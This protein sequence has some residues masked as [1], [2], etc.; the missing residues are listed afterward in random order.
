MF[1]LKPL[2]R[3]NSMFFFF[4]SLFIWGKF[5]GSN[6]L[7]CGNALITFA[8]GG[9]P[10]QLC[11]PPRLIL[12]VRECNQQPSGHKLA[13][14]IFRPPLSKSLLGLYKCLEVYYQSLNSGANSSF[15]KRFTILKLFRTV[16]LFV[17]FKAD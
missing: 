16:Y 13:S 15:C 7:L 11:P 2:E 1:S 10:V 8:P 6:A 3:K 9:C 4:L 17:K 5:S 14:L 12:L